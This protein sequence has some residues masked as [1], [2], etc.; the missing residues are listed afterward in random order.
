MKVLVRHYKSLRDVYQEIMGK[1]FEDTTELLA[2][3]TRRDTLEA[4]LRFLKPT[5][6]A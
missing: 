2:T 6:K 4:V 5:L 1:W 3:V